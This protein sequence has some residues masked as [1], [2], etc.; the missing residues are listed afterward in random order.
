M[1][2]KKK[3]SKNKKRKFKFLKKIAR[4]IYYILSQIYTFLDKVLITP[5]A[6]LLLLAQK[7]FKGR[8]KTIDRL[9]NNKIVLIV[10][11]DQIPF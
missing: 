5:L 4:G 1:A 10:L 2:K 3:T 6:K 9:L 7:P 11:A 8:S